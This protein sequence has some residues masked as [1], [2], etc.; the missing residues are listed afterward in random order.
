MSI[1][2]TGSRPIEVDGVNYRWR[3]RH[4]HTTAVQ[5]YGGPMVFA[6]QRVGVKGSVL[7]ATLAMNRDPYWGD[8]HQESVTPRIV[9]E[10]IRKAIAEGWAPSSPGKPFQ[11]DGAGLMP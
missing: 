6:A 8:I 4:R 7:V 9:A 10:C 5:D 2:K 1:R 11:L 3:I